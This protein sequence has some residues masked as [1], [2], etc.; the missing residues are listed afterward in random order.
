MISCLFFVIVSNSCFSISITLCCVS[1]I[2]YTFVDCCTFTYTSIDRYTSTSI[3]FSSP[4]SFCVVYSSIKC[5]STTSSS[6]DFSLNTGFNN[7]ARGPICSLA[8]QLFLFLCKNLIVDVPI[9][10]ISWIIVYTNASSHYMFLLLHIPKMMMNATMTL[11][12]TIEHSTH[13]HALLVSTPLL[14]LFF[15]AIMLPPLAFVCSHSFALPF[16]LLLSVV[17]QLHSLHSCCYELKDFKNTHNF[18]QHKLFSIVTSC[19]FILKLVRNTIR[20]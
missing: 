13:L 11:Q 3:T 10:Y 8:H 15:L 1:T 19:F 14:L 16:P 17:S 9:L 20:F 18:Q 5:S 7:L 12:P 2:A 6:S 4:T